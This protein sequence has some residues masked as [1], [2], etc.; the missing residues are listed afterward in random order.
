MEENAWGISEWS[1]K[2]AKNMFAGRAEVLSSG[3][4]SGRGEGGGAPL[5]VDGHS[6]KKTA[7][8]KTVAEDLWVGYA[9]K[10]GM[11][12]RKFNAASIRKRKLMKQHGGK[13]TA[14]R[15]PCVVQ[16]KKIEPHGLGL[17]KAARLAS[18][19]A[20][21]RRGNVEVSYRLDRTH[22]RTL[23]GDSFNVPEGWVRHAGMGD[24]RQ[25]SPTILRGPRR[26]TSG[27]AAG[28]RWR[29]VVLCQE[30]SRANRAA[31]EA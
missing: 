9:I 31:V 27:K 22:T 11:G 5:F 3:V 14:I 13:L 19:E 26:F 25:G 7:K 4:K 29:S 21:G 23:Q 28:H 30:A 20:H 17:I 15:S 12:E 18:V 10:A 2:G 16:I 8:K 6:K 24:A 1:T